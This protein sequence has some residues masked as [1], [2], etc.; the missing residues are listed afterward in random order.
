MMQLHAAQEADAG[1]V[2]LRSQLR[3]LADPI[4]A[5]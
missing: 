4:P 1:L 3:R 5:N 2:W